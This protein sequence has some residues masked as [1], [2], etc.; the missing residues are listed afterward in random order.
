MSL[1]V[2]LATAVLMMICGSANAEVLFSQLNSHARN[3]IKES[4]ISNVSTSEVAVVKSRID[5]MMWS[6][7]FC[8]VCD[9]KKFLSML[10]QGYF[11]CYSVYNCLD[12]KELGFTWFENYSVS[13]KPLN[14]QIEYAEV[15]KGGYRPALAFGTIPFLAFVVR[16]GVSGIGE[17]ATNDVCQISEGIGVFRMV[18]SMSFAVDGVSCESQVKSFSGEAGK[19]ISILRQLAIEANERRPPVT[20]TRRE[21]TELVYVT[22]LCRGVVR[23]LKEFNEKYVG[24]GPAFIVRLSNPRCETEFGRMLYDA[25]ADGVARGGDRKYRR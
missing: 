12:G 16:A 21:A 10:E 19:Q 7:C 11:P 5:D 1:P 23:T 2:I 17:L 24:K 15:R 20:L 14:S 18:E 9:K 3:E 4:F 6:A 8:S 25:V 22:A 13:T